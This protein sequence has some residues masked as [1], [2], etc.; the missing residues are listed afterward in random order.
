MTDETRRRPGVGSPGV[1]QANST[2]L[3]GTEDS[4]EDRQGAEV[5]QVVEVV[6]ILDATTAEALAEQITEQ[7]ENLN[8]EA[9]KLVDL[10]A[11]ALHGK[12]W[13]ALG[14]GSWSE[15]CEAKRWEFNPRTSTDRAALAAMLRS[16]GMSFREIGKLVGASTGTIRNDL[17]GVQNC[18]PA[19]V[20]GADGKTYS[21]RRPAVADV[22]ADLDGDE[23][24]EYPYLE[25]LGPDALREA[26]RCVELIRASSDEARPFRE[27]ILHKWATDPRRD[28]PRSIGPLQLFKE[29]DDRV[30]FAVDTIKEWQY[31]LERVEAARH[32]PEYVLVLAE[33]ATR[34]ADLA[35]VVAR[36]FPH[37]R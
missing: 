32:S 4:P 3:I 12:A 22:A 1:E 20:T 24:A 19:E 9:G 14:Y 8:V 18:T 7:T 6:T 25:H 11:E 35:E 23:L 33:V 29:Q 30:R 10:I 17:S 28:D 34:D 13:V 26:L 5:V 21:A 36:E 2:P 15:L 27:D 37:V 16:N 31:A